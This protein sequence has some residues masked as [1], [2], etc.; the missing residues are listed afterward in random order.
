MANEAYPWMNSG[1]SPLDLTTPLAEGMRQGLAS[2]VADNSNANSIADRQERIRAS[3]AQEQ[4][5]KDNFGLQEKAQDF[6][7]SVWN[8]QADMRATQLD[9]AKTNLSAANTQM[10]MVRDG[11]PILNNFITDLHAK[12]PTELLDATIP[13]GL[14]LEQQKQATQALTDARQTHSAIAAANVVTQQQQAMTLLQQAGQDPENF[15]DNST[16]MLDMTAV[17]QALKGVTQADETFKSDLHA[18]EMQSI[19]APK[20]ANMD[21]RQL[22]DREYQ[23]LNNYTSDANR[24]KKMG[25]GSPAQIAA[26]NA[27]VQQQ[28]ER[29]QALNSGQDINDIPSLVPDNTPLTSSPTISEPSPLPSGAVEYEYKGKKGF[30]LNGFFYPAKIDGNKYVPNP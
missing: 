26:A 13:G 11:Q 27:K 19:Y 9:L 12:S 30:K 4:Q 29:L 2:R 22:I 21:R 10:A 24:L 5:M 15:K 18:K 6:Q 8:S 17:G 14:T 1:P 7:Q 3:M 25:G 23:L 28:Q 20:Q 16:G